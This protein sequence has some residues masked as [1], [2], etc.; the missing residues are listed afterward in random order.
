MDIWQPVLKI[1]HINTKVTFLKKFDI[2]NI[3]NFIIYSFNFGVYG[4]IFK[5]FGP[6]LVVTYP[7]FSFIKF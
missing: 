6:E 1:C 7:L 4:P 3:H 5:I 2:S